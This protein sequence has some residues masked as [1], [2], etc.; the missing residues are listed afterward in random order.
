MFYKFVLYYIYIFT[1]THIWFGCF[2]SSLLSKCSL[3]FFRHST[4][5]QTNKV[6][7]STSQ[8]IKQ[9]SDI[10]SGSSRVLYAP[11]S[12]SFIVIL[13]NKQWIEQHLRLLK[14][15]LFYCTARP[16]APDT[17]KNRTL[18]VCAELWGSAEG[19]MFSVGFINSLLWLLNSYF[20][21]SDGAGRK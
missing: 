1:Y 8:L 13:K 10:I 12:P 6:I 7:T 2:E 15:I 11:S 4:Q 9:L 18:R 5:Q 14:L 20:W 19:M 16:S 17:T 3:F 21:M